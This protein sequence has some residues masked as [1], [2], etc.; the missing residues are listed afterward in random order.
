MTGRAE[1]RLRPAGQAGRPPRAPRSASSERSRWCG[2]TGFE[3]PPPDQLSG[4][5]RQRVA[6]ARALVNRPRVLLLDEPLGRARPQAAPA[7]AGRAQA[8]PAGGR[9]HLHLRDPRPGRGAFDERSHRGHGQRPRPAGRHAAT[10]S[11][12]SPS[13]Q[14]RRRVRRRVEPARAAR[15]SRVEASVAQLRLGPRD[16]RARPTSR[17]GCGQAQPRSSPCGP[18]GSR[19]IE[20]PSAATTTDCRASGT[21][22]ESFMPGP[23]TRFVVELEGGGELMVVRQNSRT[24]FED[25]EAS[26]AGGDSHLGDASTLASSVQPRRGL[27]M[28]KVNWRRIE[29]L[30]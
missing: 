5:Q 3:R 23:T 2:S 29:A 19:S 13:S 26:G 7:A 21:V 9:D 24:S 10:R 11:T 17:T 8:D 30:A 25:A 22:R 20:A 4:G 14:L 15:S 16:E 18:S 27:R 28:R 6:L 1:R 12:T